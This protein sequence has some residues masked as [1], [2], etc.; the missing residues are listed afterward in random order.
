MRAA[1]LNPCH[2][3]ARIGVIEFRR[4]AETFM[5]R[6]GLYKISTEFLDGAGI[7]NV[8]VIYCTTAGCTGEVRTFTPLAATPAPAGSGKVKRPHKSIRPFLGNIRGHV[9]SSPWDSQ[10]PIAMMALK[11]KQWPS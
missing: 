10:G 3:I 6:N 5:I 11:S 7:S 1:S 8:H 2:V 9:R 4:N